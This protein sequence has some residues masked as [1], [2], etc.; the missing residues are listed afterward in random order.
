LL[1]ACDK[2]LIEVVETLEIERVLAVGRFVE[3]RSRLALKNAGKENIPVDF[4][5]HPSPIN[6]KANAGWDQIVKDQLKQAG[7]D[8][9]FQHFDNP[10]TTQYGGTRGC[11]SPIS[12]ATEEPTPE[13]SPS[14][15][16]ASSPV[17]HFPGSSMN[18]ECSSASASSVSLCHGDL[19]EVQ[20]YGMNPMRI[21]PVPSAAAMRP[22][23]TAHHPQVTHDF[24]QSFRNSQRMEANARAFQYQ[25]ELPVSQSLSGTSAVGSVAS[26]GHMHPQMSSSFHH[27]SNFV[28][29]QTGLPSYYAPYHAP[30][31]IPQYSMHSYYPPTPHHPT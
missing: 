10:L 28:L 4:I 24:M 21:A 31:Y 13:I 30:A 5:M 3:E 2:A 22:G 29:P 14:A 17:M 9:Y 8:Q 7:V 16:P 19:S 6:P 27:H 26:H 25:E 1:Q 18:E 23:L 12:P 15:L 20:A 11:P